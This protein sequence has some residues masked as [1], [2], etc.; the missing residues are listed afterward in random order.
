MNETIDDFRDF[1]K[2]QD[3]LVAATVK[4]APSD[5][6]IATEIVRL[7]DDIWGARKRTL[8]NAFRVGQ[9]LSQQKSKIEHGEWMT[10]CQTH[11]PKIPERMIQRY[12]QLRENEDW[13]RE[14]F[15]KTDTVSDLP[16]GIRGALEALQDRDRSDA[17]ASD[18]ESIST[19]DPLSLDSNASGPPP[20][21][22]I[23]DPHPQT[24]DYPWDKEHKEN[25]EPTNSQYQRAEAPGQATKPKPQ[26]GPVTSVDPFTDCQK[27]KVW[28]LTD[29]FVDKLANT[30]QPLD[31]LNV[32]DLAIRRMREH[33]RDYKD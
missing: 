18:L 10:W 28:E 12:M 24:P 1:Y 8:E 20:E 19:K 30:Y 23:D 17:F 7:H 33:R 16:F 31:M 32:L 15:L 6:D 4:Q 13:L 22:V 2:T 9:L 3:A 27:R 11:I 14:H 21:E 5:Q 29:V 25:P 26:T